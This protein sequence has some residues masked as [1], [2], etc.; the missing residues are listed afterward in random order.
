M[1]TPQDL[2]DFA[3]RFSLSEGIIR[4]AAELDSLKVL[5]LGDGIE[6]RMW[7]SGPKADRLQKR[8]HKLRD[9][10]AVG[11]AGSSQSRKPYVE[12]PLS[13]PAGNSRGTRS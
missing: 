6:L 5:H 10:R 1:T 3:V 13:D 7:L 12:P 2:E 11:S 4:S 9:R 8:R